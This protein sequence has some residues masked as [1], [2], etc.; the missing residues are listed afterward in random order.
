MSQPHG[1]CSKC[2]G[3]ILGDGYRTVLHCQNADW[4]A[5][6]GREP[7]SGPVECGPQLERPEEMV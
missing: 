4:N 1:T 5:I 2:G 3:T 7:D 6:E